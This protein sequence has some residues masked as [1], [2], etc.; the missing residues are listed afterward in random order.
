M[1]PRTG[2]DLTVERWLV[3]A[4]LAMVMV[5]AHV[6]ARRL[7]RRRRTT[8]SGAVPPVPADLLERESGRAEMLLF[9]GPWCAA[10]GPVREELAAVHGPGAVVEVDVSRHPDLA[11]RY[12]IRTTPTL[13]VVGE[14]GAVRRRLAGAPA[15]TELLRSSG[16]RTRPA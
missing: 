15:V 9:T 12:D 6:G 7:E 2:G 1:R 13:L 14:D 16:P 8:D 10:C 4:A 11:E 5:A 3:V